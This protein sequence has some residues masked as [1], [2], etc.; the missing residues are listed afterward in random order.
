MKNSIVCE[1][2]GTE[3]PH[4]K[5]NCG[6]CNS[7]I[8]PRVVNIDFW[9]IWW[10]IFESPVKSFKEIIFAEHKNFVSI[11]LLLAGFKFFLH[12]VILSQALNQ[13]RE[14]LD[15]LSINMVLSMGY[16]ISLVSVMSLMITLLNRSLGVSTRFKDNLAIYVYSFLPQLF[17][18]FIFVPVEY[19]VFGRYWFFQNPSPFDIKETIAWM[20]LILEII[21]LGWGFLLSIFATYAQTK[22]KIYSLIIGIVFSG[23]LLLSNLYLPLLPF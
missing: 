17:A 11:I 14:V 19:A 9:K 8:R 21:M 16:T 7:Y 15:Y 6:K 23:I 1:N 4:F 3:N 22:S 20:M 10:K 18:L 5:L 2:C 12:S 13:N